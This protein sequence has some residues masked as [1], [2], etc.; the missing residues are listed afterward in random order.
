MQSPLLTSK[1]TDR[2]NPTPPSVRVL[3]DNQ[4]YFTKP[5]KTMVLQHRPSCSVSKRWRGETSHYT[6]YDAPN[7]HPGLLLEFGFR[8][9][10]CYWSAELT[11]RQA[12]ELS[13]I[14]NVG[15]LENC[16]CLDA[17]DLARECVN[18]IDVRIGQRTSLPLRLL[19]STTFRT[20]KH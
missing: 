2:R 6:V 17:N 10:S 8:H 11:R 18:A 1:Y 15:T 9:F 20:G 3:C 13:S 12:M 7:V 19:R 4:R 14:L 16:S 5:T